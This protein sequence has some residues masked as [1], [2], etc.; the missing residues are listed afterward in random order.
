ML[1]N[2]GAMVQRLS[3]RGYRVSTDGNGAHPEIFR[4]QGWKPRLARGLAVQAYSG[5]RSQRLRPPLIAPPA[6]HLAR[7]CNP[8]R[9]LQKACT[10]L[11]ASLSTAESGISGRIRCN[12]GVVRYQSFSPDAAIAAARFFNSFIGTSLMWVATCQ[13][14]PKGSSKE[15]LRSP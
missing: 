7:K 11:C 1:G 5:L 3:G 12:Q 10:L 2:A 13:T 6:R 8:L 14:C 15:P 4:H 9:S